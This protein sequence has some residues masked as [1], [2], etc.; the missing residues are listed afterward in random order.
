MRRFV[1]DQSSQVHPAS[2]SRRGT[3]SVTEGLTNGRMEI[4]V[5]KFGCHP[6][7]QFWEL[8]SVL[9]ISNTYQTFFLSWK[10]PQAESNC[11]VFISSREMFQHFVS[12]LKHK[13]SFGDGKCFPID[14]VVVCWCLQEHH[15]Y[16]LFGLLNLFPPS[17]PRNNKTSFSFWGQWEV[18]KKIPH[19]GDTN[20]LDRCGK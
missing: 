5:S 2:E 9:F 1:F 12:T 18:F 6:P 7:A 15:L 17:P 3:V 20:S 19:T 14:L 10:A 16:D 11:L 8:L 13:R 4:L